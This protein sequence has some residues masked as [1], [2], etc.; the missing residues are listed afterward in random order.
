MNANRSRADIN[1]APLGARLCVEALADHVAKRGPSVQVLTRLQG[2]P[3][4]WRRYMVG[5]R[6]SGAR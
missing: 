3:R 5:Q 1:D 2:A 4:G 6:A